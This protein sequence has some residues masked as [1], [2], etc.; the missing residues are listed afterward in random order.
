MKKI[1]IPFIA[2]ALILFQS[3]EET[4]PVIYDGVQTL[5][6][7]DGSSLTLS[8][9]ENTSKDI[10]VT[11]GASTISTS[12]RTVTIAVNEDITKTTV[13]SSQYSI[14]LTVTIPAGSYFADFNVTGIDDLV[15]TTSGGNLVLTLSEAS[16]TGAVLSQD[17]LTI[18]IKKVCPIPAG[19]FQGQYLMEQI[20]PIHADNGVQTFENQILTLV[21]DP[22][23][24]FARS[25]E[26]VFLEAAGIGNPA[27]KIQFSLSCGNTV[28]FNN[29]ASSLL[30]EQG[31][32]PINFGAPAEALLS[33]FD[34]SDDSVFEFSIVEYFTEDGD[35]G[36]DP[37]VTKFK[38]T[39]Q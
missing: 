23:N 13:L 20:T 27:T 10:T 35:C 15:L 34:S 12:D 38:F 19:S 9:I 17:E 3:C 39:K 21:E 26:A 30:C 2:F 37:L 6:Y 32:P 5:V 14:P 29:I 11:I 16:E 31:A 36:V 25:F 18:S 28:P 7:F 8:V 1:L 24:A 22:G 33:N 4:Q